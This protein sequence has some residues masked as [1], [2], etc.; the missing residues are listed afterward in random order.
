[1][2]IRTLV[3][4]L[5]AGMTSAAGA[6]DAIKSGNWEYSATAAGVTQLPPGMQASPNMR[7]GPE[8]LTFVQT[9]CITAADP[10]PSMHGSNLCT[11]DKTETNGGTLRWSVT[12]TSPKF[13][14]HEDWVVHYHG[15]TMD[16]Q[17]TLHGNMPDNRPPIEK[18]QQISGRYLGPCDAK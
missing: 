18:T 9:R 15:D 7:L 8:G 5:L 6:Q 1:M 12:C 10:F 3:V 16:G 14:F 13:T 17:F 4:S 2:A 11:M